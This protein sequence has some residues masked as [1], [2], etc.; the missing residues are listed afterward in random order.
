LAP[1]AY[2]EVAEALL[3]GESDLELEA[4]SVD[5]SGSS[6]SEAKRKRPAAVIIKPATAKPKRG[7]VEHCYRAA[8]WLV[9][10]PDPARG[11]SESPSRAGRGGRLWLRGGWRGGHAS[12]QRRGW[13]ARRGRY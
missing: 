4:G 11:E 9:G 7:R 5:T 6:A 3:E 12:W 8:G 13:G 2:R 1:E 10:G